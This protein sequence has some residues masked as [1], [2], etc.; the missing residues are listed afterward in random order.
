M[1]IQHDWRYFDH[2]LEGP[3]W[4]IHINQRLET[5]RLTAIALDNI[6]E[7]SSFLSDGY[8]PKEEHFAPWEILS[9]ENIYFAEQQP[10]HFFQENP[11]EM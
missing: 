11:L 1:V 6:K 5:K 4:Q 9:T 10:S 8:T 7:K 2:T 3:K